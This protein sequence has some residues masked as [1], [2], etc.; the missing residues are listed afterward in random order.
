MNLILFVSGLVLVVAGALFLMLPTHSAQSA[1]S[2]A[3]PRQPV[4]ERGQ[5]D[6]LFTWAIGVALIA[7]GLF[8]ILLKLAI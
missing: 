2:A 6:R 8:L 5:T 7:V 1:L 4:P 3:G